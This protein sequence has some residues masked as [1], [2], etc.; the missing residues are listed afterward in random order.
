MFTKIA[1]YQYG[2]VGSMSICGSCDGKYYPHICEVYD[3]LAVHTHSHKV[4]RD[5]LTKHN[6]ILVINIVRLPIDRNISAFWE[7]I[8]SSC[9]QY[10]NLS[11]DE[12]D[13]IY[14]K[15]EKYSIKDTDSWMNDFFKTLNINPDTFEFDEE[16]K[17]TEIKKDGNTFL[18]LRFEDFDYFAKYVL[19]KYGINNVQKLHVS[20]QKYYG[21]KYIEHKKMHKINPNE[22][23]E[24]RKSMFVNK[25]YSNDIID[26]YISKYKIN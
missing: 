22:E 8:K 4:M 5:V 21:D 24:I 19:P 16:Q 10:K 1:I 14:Q 20:S 17:F 26:Q 25:Y 15:T 18:F 9:P 6:N 11:I 13:E 12:I 2:K 23:E 3:S 7:N